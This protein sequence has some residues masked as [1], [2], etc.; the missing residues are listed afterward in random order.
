M[1]MG[2]HVMTASDGG[3]SFVRRWQL[4]EML[5]NFREVAGLTQSQ[6]IE[7]LRRAGGKWSV[8]KLSRIENHENGVRPNE[9]AQLLELYGVAEP[10]RV[11]VLELAVLARER[12]WRTAY[13]ADL[14]ESLRG[15]VSL[16]AGATAI[17]QFTTT[18]VPGLLQ[19]ADYTRAVI[20]ATGPEVGSPIELERLVARRLT[21][22][23]VLR[24]PASPAFHAILDESVLLR[25]VG[26]GPVMRDQMRKLA[27]LTGHEH[28]TVQVLTLESGGGPGVEGPF[29][30][31][32]L[33]KPAPD[34][35]YGE[36]AVT[37]SLYV[38]DSDRVRACTMRFGMLSQLALSR[39]E[40]AER[41]AAAAR[42]FE[43]V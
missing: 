38:S 9:V 33:P 13:G 37:G 6:A 8:A 29:T 16:E 34:V 1:R 5:K 22:Q 10:E 4:A 3:S 12:E 20:E 18:A 25:P 35:L 23:H 26:G 28:L 17:R 11:P 30:L 42:R 39:A 19:T 43:Q 15:L 24:G 31:L 2:E 7:Q 40:S 36:G 14:P 32:S 41:I 21:R 27:D